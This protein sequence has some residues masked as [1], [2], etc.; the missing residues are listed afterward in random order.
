VT[1]TGWTRVP[2]A[3]TTDEV[4]GGRW[5]SLRTARREWL[6]TNPDPAV[7]LGRGSV[8]PSD[9]FVDAGGV[10]ECVPT[11]RGVPDHGGAWSREWSPGP[12]SVDLPGVGR[13]TRA[14]GT[15]GRGVEVGYELEGAPGTPF[16]HAVHALLDVGPNAHITVPEATSM[17]VLDPEPHL[18]P[19]PSGLDRLGPDDGTATCAL[20]TGCREV[21]VVDGDD[22]LSLTWSAPGRDELCSLLLWRN[23]R[24]WPVEAPYR[25]IGVEPMVGRAADLGSAG[26]G[27][28]ARIGPDG[29][30][31]WNLTLVA[32]ERS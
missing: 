29:R 3:V 22:A 15:T 17:T 24:G 21:L 11:I 26:A 25:S 18:L 31:V 12:A 14:I 32:L 27:D 6:W 2:L 19:W 4:H 7:V 5:T 10:E 9:P 1:G 30:H 20:L 13:L 28:V 16:L 23:L 8:S